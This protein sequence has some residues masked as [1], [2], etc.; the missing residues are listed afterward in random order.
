M[1]RYVVVTPRDPV[2]VRDGRPFGTGGRM[3]P[4][5]WP[6]PSLVA[7]SLRTILGLRR[8]GGGVFDEELVKAVLNLAIRGPLGYADG[9]LWL[10]TPRDIICFI[11][12]GKLDYMTLRPKRMADGEYCNLPHPSLL[13]LGVDVDA[14][15]KPCAPL[16]TMEKLS[17]WLLNPLGKGFAVP[18][19]T[20][21]F[22][23]DCGPLPAR[24][25]RSH[26]AIDPNTLASMES[27]LFET[28]GL[29][30]ERVRKDENGRREFHQEPL[31][32]VIRIGRADGFTF[33]LSGL[34]G[35]YPLGGER[36]L[37]RWRA[38]S[39]IDE[40]W[41]CP[42]DLKKALS[43]AT[44]VRMVLATPAIFTG[45][46]LPGWLHDANGY[47]EGSP[48]DSD[49]RLRLVGAVLERWQPISGWSVENGKAGPKPVRRM[50]GAG[51]VYFFDV[52]GGLAAPL[53]DDWLAAVSD[54]EQDRREGFGLALWG[55][56]QHEQHDLGRT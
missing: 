8:N 6:T 47:L 18:H 25:A 14:K 50:V 21:V 51:G 16:W 26:T 56:S 45:G 23:E 28:V 39:G 46:W 20:D 30:F 11:K 43:K 48:P 32:L 44:Q 55:V 54:G 42:A 53:A 7:G 36:R 3:K 52:V 12:E 34:D 9:K 4:L 24:S 2:I 40:L 41:H 10:P 13:P 15:A 17:E 29:D 19:E 35:L 31:E 1:T 27:K 37:A 22:G 5:G 33:E 49:I 38:L